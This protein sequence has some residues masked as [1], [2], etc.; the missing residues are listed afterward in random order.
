M[1]NSRNIDTTKMNKFE[2]TLHFIRTHILNDSP[3][4]GKIY[5]VG[6]CVRDEL[7][8]ERYTDVDLLINMPDGQK[9]F[10]EHLCAAYPDTCKGPF[11]Y[12][13]YGTTAMDVVIG[14]SVTLVECVEPHI[15][16]YDTDGVTLIDTRFC[17]LVED[18]LRRDYT[19]NALYKNLHTGQVMDPTGMGRKDLEQGLLRTPLDPTIIYRQDPIRMLRGIRFKYQKGFRLDEEARKAIVVLHDEMAKAAPK[20]MR[21]ELHKILKT[22]ACADALTELHECGLLQYVMPGFERILTDTAVVAGLDK[23]MTGWEHA[24][25]ALNTITQNS[26]YVDTTTKLAVIVLHYAD[27]H[28]TAVTSELLQEGLIGKEKIG[29]VIY[30]VT[31]YFRYRA[32]FDKGKCVVK[33]RTLANFVKTMGKYLNTFRHIVNAFN[34]GMYETAL[35]PVA[36]LTTSSSKDE[37]PSIA[38][39][40]PGGDNR[41]RKK[42]TKRRKPCKRAYFRRKRHGNGGG[43]AR[44]ADE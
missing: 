16:H 15:E 25:I 10:V 17:T 36:P 21:D 3:F 38:S 14:G 43:S 20:R 26:H 41:N 22:T 42:K 44:S 33:N 13:R 7:L 35:L 27:R 8:G 9:A 11:Y 28:G 31:M 5:L 19:C 30:L 32:F 18:A 12:Q 6:G 24:L 4:Y 2:R 39:P 34:R 1:P 37:T 40:K 29:N 23:K